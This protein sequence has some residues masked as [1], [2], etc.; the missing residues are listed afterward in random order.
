[1]MSYPDRENQFFEMFHKPVVEQPERASSSLKARLYTAL[2]RQEQQTGRLMDLERTKES[3]RQ[4]CVF[5]E[6]VQIAP[7]GSRAKSSFICGVCHARILAE[8]FERP[9]IFWP[10]C[11][12]VSFKRS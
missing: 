3:G 7:I 12:Y 8:H 6:L 5:E 1:M 9:P 4:L 10:G 2:I 11:P